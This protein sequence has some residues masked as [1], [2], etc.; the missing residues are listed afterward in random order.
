[1]KNIDEEINAAVFFP[2]LFYRV[3]DALVVHNIK[4]KEESVGGS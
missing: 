2:H 1:M 4:A 3:G